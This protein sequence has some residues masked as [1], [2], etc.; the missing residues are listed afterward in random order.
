MSHTIETLIEDSKKIA[1]QMGHGFVTI[2]H[3]S[4]AVITIPSIRKFFDHA[5]LDPQRI[6]DKLL[7][8]VKK[9]SLPA[10]GGSAVD[11]PIQTMAFVALMNDIKK[12]SIIEQ[13]QAND[14]SIEPYFILIECLSFKETIFEAVLQTENTTNGE[15]AITLQSYINDLNYDLDIQETQAQMSDEPALPNQVGRGKSNK[16]PLEEF[17][18]NLSKEASDGKL[19]PMIGRVTELQDMIQVLARKTKKNV[20]LTGDAG[21]G[22]TQLANGLALAISTGNVPESLKSS[23]IF[24]LNVSSLL[25]GTKF[26]G[27]F[28][29]RVDALIK[30]LKERPDIILFIDEIHTIMGAGSSGSGGMDICERTDRTEYVEDIGIY[31][32]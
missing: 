28:E 14:L 11:G 25:A 23:L 19:E 27:D 5:N 16:S 21:V 31:V 22:K 24:S 1:E 10:V 13:L 9:M 32:E 17:C 29:A 18:V 15:L 7:N 26:R 8:A 12:Q 4:I 2:D 20:I 3:L 30:E 6:T